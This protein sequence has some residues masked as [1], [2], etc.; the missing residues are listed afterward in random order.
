MYTGSILHLRRSVRSYHS[1]PKRLPIFSPSRRLGA[2]Q[3]SERVTL[4]FAQPG[5]HLQNRC[6]RI[7]QRYKPTLSPA[8]SI[9]RQALHHTPKS[10]HT[11]V[12]SPTV[13]VDSMHDPATGT[14]QYIVADPHSLDAV[15]IDSVLDHDMATHTIST[16]TADGL[17]SLIQAKG[18][19]IIRILET[20]AHADHLTAASY[21]QTALERDQDFKPPICIGKRIREVQRLFGQRYGVPES[22]LNSAFDQLMDD[23]EEFDIGQLKA[24]VVHLPGHTPDHV[25][26]LI[27]GVQPHSPSKGLM[28]SANTSSRRQ[29]LLRRH[30]VQRRPGH[31]TLRLS[32]RQRQRSVPLDSQVAEPTR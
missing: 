28:K 15:I 7:H 30:C 26:Y 22:E 5:L 17:R 13:T 11:E 32:R 21:L 10:I 8:R 9:P 24:K 6:R 27:E 14:W 3:F 12:M 20:H 31:R 2:Y 1:P 4:A 16:H 23:D 25:G 18:F 29:R 19:K